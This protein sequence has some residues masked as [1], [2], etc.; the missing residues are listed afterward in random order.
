MARTAR[1][2]ASST[3]LL[4]ILEAKMNFS[5]QLLVAKVNKKCSFILSKASEP[6]IGFGLLFRINILAQAMN[7]IHSMDAS[8]SDAQRRYSRRRILSQ[9]LTSLAENRNYFSSGS[10]YKK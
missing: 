7:G 10:V 5:S 4:E 1:P 2:L 8:A 6:L 3:V 9:N